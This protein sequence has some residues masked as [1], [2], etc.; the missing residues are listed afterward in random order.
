MNRKADERNIRKLTR[1]GKLS[2]AVTIPRD[3]VVELGWREGQKVVAK[4][5]GRGVFIEDWQPKD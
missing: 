5:R 4:K 1:L 2:I 3:L